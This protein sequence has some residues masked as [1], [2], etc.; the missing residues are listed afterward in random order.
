MENIAKS[1]EKNF[2]GNFIGFVILRKL[3]SVMGE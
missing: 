1:R 3:D 2:R